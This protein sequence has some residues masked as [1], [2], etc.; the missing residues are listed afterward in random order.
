MAELQSRAGQSGFVGRMT[1]IDGGRTAENE[2]HVVEKWNE[3]K[4]NLYRMIAALWS[5]LVMGACDAA[6]GVGFLFDRTFAVC[7]TYWRNSH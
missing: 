4:A 3:P 2:S 6:Y 5:F 7:N 1:S